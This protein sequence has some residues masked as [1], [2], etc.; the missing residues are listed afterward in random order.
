MSHTTLTLVTPTPTP[1]DFALGRLLRDIRKEVR[2]QFWAEGSDTDVATTR[3]ATLRTIIERVMLERGGGNRGQI[4]EYLLAAA[5][6]QLTLDR[7]EV[8]S[9]LQLFP[10][11][12]GQA[13]DYLLGNALAVIAAWIRQ[14][15]LTDEALGREDLNRRRRRRRPVRTTGS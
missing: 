9:W 11:L 8:E 1:R 12:T 3:K 15:L 4:D 7:Y 13:S 2:E 6:T 10:W 14:E 5:R